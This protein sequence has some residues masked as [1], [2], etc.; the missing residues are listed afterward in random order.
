MFDN[1]LSKNIYKYVDEIDSMY[2]LDDNTLIARAHGVYGGALYKTNL[3]TRE[4]ET[5][6]DDVNIDELQYIDN[7]IFYF[8]S[9]SVMFFRKDLLTCEVKEFPQLAEASVFGIKDKKIYINRNKTIEEYD[10]DG[11]LIGV[12]NTEIDIATGI[13]EILPFRDNYIINYQFGFYYKKAFIDLE[14]NQGFNN[15]LFCAEKWTANDDYLVVCTSQFAPKAVQPKLKIFIPNTTENGWNLI[16]EWESEH[17]VDSLQIL[18]GVIYLFT[19]K[20]VFIA[21]DFNC[22]VL[23]EIQLEKNT[24]GFCVRQ[25]GKK[26]AYAYS[27]YLKVI[28]L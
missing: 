16:S 11:N 20:N 21:L 27:K 23:K 15:T 1:I 6:V 25:D 19:T 14:L 7:Y 24:L 13:P 5:I 17:F 9:S 4:T 3:L 12:K 26:L 28:D 18:N 2:F 8:K 10:F 22:N